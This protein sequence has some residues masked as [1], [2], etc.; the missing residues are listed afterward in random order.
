MLENEKRLNELAEEEEKKEEEKKKEIDNT[1]KLE[2]STKMD[3][4][5]VF[6]MPEP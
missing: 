4:E 1:I 6:G 2:P 5:N 3:L